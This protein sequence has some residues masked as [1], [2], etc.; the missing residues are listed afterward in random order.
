MFDVWLR[1]EYVS[2]DGYVKN[3]TYVGGTKHTY[4]I[5]DKIFPMYRHRHIRSGVRY[6]LG[7]VLKVVLVVHYQTLSFVA[8]IL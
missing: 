6:I 5:S 3:Q 7:K 8:M 2:E 1:S 4:N